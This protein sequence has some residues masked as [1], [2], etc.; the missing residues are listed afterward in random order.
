MRLRSILIFLIA[1]A[2]IFAGLWVFLGM[3]TQ[4]ELVPEAAQSSEPLTLA[5][6]GERANQG[7]GWLRSTLGLAA[8]LGMSVLGGL[9]TAWLTSSRR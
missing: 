7:D 3:G 2:V 1:T 4:S 8:N 9:I 6:R 5:R